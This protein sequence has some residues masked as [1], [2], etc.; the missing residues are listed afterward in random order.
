[1]L[2]LG[3]LGKH[4]LVSGA[5]NHDAQAD[6]ASFGKHFHYAHVSTLHSL[7]EG[8]L[9]IFISSIGG[10]AP[11]TQERSHNVRVPRPRCPRERCSTVFIRSVR[12]DTLPSQKHLRNT[13]LPKAHRRAVWPPSSGMSGV[14]SN[15]YCAS[16]LNVLS[17]NSM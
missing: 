7:R 1:M 14:A 4:C 8:C 12:S 13:Y 6:P 16:Y 2:S 11:P 15:M 9:T 3:R 17:Q 5:W 10:D